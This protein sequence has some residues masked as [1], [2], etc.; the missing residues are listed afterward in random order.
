MNRQAIDGPGAALDELAGDYGGVRG[1]LCAGALLLGYLGG[2][3]GCNAGACNA[4]SWLLYDAVGRLDECVGALR[5]LVGS[6][7]RAMSGMAFDPD[8]GPSMSLWLSYTGSQLERAARARGEMAR[9]VEAAWAA[10]R[11]GEAVPDG[12][13]R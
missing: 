5:G 6:A 2:L 12:G 8:L 3:P 10:G 9:V 11:G 1:A 13:A 4:V 7:G